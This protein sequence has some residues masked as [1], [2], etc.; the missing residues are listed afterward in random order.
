MPRENRKKPKVKRKTHKTVRDTSR[1][2]TQFSFPYEKYRIRKIIQRVLGLSDMAAEKLLVQV[3]AQFSGRHE[4][5]R[6]IFDRHLHKVEAL[7]S[8]RTPC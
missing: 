5:I 6:Q 8:T 2:I 3:L 4:D 1:V 7:S